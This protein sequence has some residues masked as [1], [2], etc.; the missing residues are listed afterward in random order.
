MEHVTLT[1]QELKKKKKLQNSEKEIYMK[2]N[3]AYKFYL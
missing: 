3:G 1:A 2:M